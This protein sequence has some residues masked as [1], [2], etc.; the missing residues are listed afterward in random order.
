MGTACDNCLTL[1]AN[2]FTLRDITQEAISICR[3]IQQIGVKED[4]TLLHVSEILKGSKNQK[5][6]EKNHHK[7]EMHSKLST[8]KKNDIERIIRRLIFMGYLSEEVKVLSYTD[9]VACYVKLGPKANQLTR[10]RVTD[11]IEFDF[12]GGD[13]TKSRYCLQFCILFSI[14]L[15]L[16]IHVTQ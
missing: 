11:K 12:I 6:M 4:V 7:L 15:K 5:V 9:T 13:A 10:D 2:A 3:G 1:K 16:I 14:F 8:Y